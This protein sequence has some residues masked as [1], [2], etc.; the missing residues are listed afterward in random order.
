MHHSIKR[1]DQL[2]LP[3]PDTE[4][5]IDFQEVEPATLMGRSTAPPE[6]GLPPM[7]PCNLEAGGVL[8]FQV[9]PTKTVFRQPVSIEGAA[10]EA[11]I[12]RPTA[13]PEGHTLDST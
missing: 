10:S 4:E 13:P 7:N 2:V 12:D 11:Q 9:V 6:L 3:C 8:E 5:D 1:P